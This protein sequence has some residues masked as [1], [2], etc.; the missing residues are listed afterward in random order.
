MD[1]KQLTEIANNLHRLPAMEERLR[2]LNQRI[3][4]AE[5]E[6]TS[7][8]VRYEA[9][10]KDVEKL[11]KESLSVM[12]LRLT[13]LYEKK[14]DKETEEMIQAK[15]AYDKA[16]ERVRELTRE[17][18]ELGQRIADLR[19]D[20]MLYEAEL[21]RREDEIYRQSSGETA[22]KYKELEN[23]KASIIKQITEIDE[24]IRAAER[25]RRTAVKIVE[26][27]DKAD[28]WATYDVWFKGGI[29]THMAKYG[30]VD[31]AEAEFNRLNSQL[32]DLKKELKDINMVLNAEYTGIDSFT[33]AVDFW[34]DNIFTDW[35]V[36]DQIRSNR[37]KAAR[38]AGNLQRI[39][40]TL[41]QKKAAAKKQAD[42]IDYQKK[43]L[44]MNN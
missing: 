20:K 42:S 30:H 26:H 17:R 25:A 29:I 32:R 27:L 43:M 18:E 44:L 23:E 2:K 14:L 4:E 19:R 9:E 21:K 34:F 39:V 6:L 12:L 15:L 1:Q 37:D 22:A 13:G 16:A 36:R 40:T 3:A 7:L 33:R 35:N 11:E 10:S 5:K 31:D 28:S 38:L 41:E 24:A 8:L